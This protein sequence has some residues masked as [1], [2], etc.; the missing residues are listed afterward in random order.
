MPT[1]T[2]SEK[3]ILVTRELAA[4]RG[5]VWK[6]WTT[7]EGVKKWWG[8]KD[9]TAPRVEIDL[10]KGG[11]FLLCMR[12][13]GFDG[14]LKDYYNVGEFQEV[15][16][17]ERIV[18]SMSFS[19]EKGEVVPASYYG[20]PGDWPHHVTVT[21]T[22]EDAD[23]G[24]KVTV[25][26]VGVPAEVHDPATQGWEM[27]FDKAEA[28]LKGAG[29]GIPAMQKIITSLLFVGKQAGKAE[30]AIRLYTSLFKDSK[31][32]MLER[33]APG[34]GDTVGTIK[35]GSFT[36]A[37]QTFNAMD[38][39]RP[40]QFGFTPAVNLFVTCESE[41][42]LDAPYKRLSTGGSIQIPLGKYPFAEKYCWLNDKYGVS[43]QLFFPPRRAPPS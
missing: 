22:F 9:F 31:I 16:P 12:G 5:E 28:A 32:L 18:T 27:Q 36:L 8:P 1:K 23:G 19:D 6:L 37:G 20:M 42:E 26:E 24:T 3:D 30:E 41:A 7:P 25:R 15:A 10:R 21:M 29:A 2:G 43:W 34:E 33:Y 11:R 4:P 39:G 17:M 13:A 35:F 14:V 40:H 38:S